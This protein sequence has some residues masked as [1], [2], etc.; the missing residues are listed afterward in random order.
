[1]FP[2]TIVV[3]YQCDGKLPLCQGRRRSADACD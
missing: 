3:R 1:L 2:L